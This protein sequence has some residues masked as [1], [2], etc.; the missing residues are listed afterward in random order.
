MMVSKI[1]K[2][3]LVGI[4]FILVV[5]VI[6]QNSA[7]PTDKGLVKAN[8]GNEGYVIGWD[9]YEGQTCASKNVRPPSLGK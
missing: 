6:Y 7:T 8:N 9:F 5:V 1:I 3:A 2:R 4:G